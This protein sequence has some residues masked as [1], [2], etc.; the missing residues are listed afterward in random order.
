[1][2][3]RKPLA[4]TSAIALALSAQAIAEEKPDN[5][6]LDQQEEIVIYGEKQ[7]KSLQETPVSVGV[8]T[9]EDLSNS[10]IMDFN[11]VYNRLANVSSLRGGNESLFSIRGISVQGLADN[12]AS[13]T[14]GVYVDD[15]AL[16]NLSIRYN[17][18]NVWDAEQ[19]EVYR[20]PQG[21]IQGSNSLAGAVYVKTADPSYEWSGKAQAT[22]GNFNTKRHSIAGGGAIIDDT[23]AIRIAADDYRSD[24][25]VENVTRNEKDYAGF[26][27]QNVRG[28]ILFEPT[29]KLSTLLTVAHAKN[30]MG[31]NPASVYEDPYS[32]KAYSDHNAFH[33]T[34]INSSSLKVS[35]DLTDSLK[36]TSL[37][38]YS[39]ELFD[40]KD[41]FDSTAVS[42]GTVESTGESESYSQEL[43]LNFESDSIQG[44]AGLYARKLNREDIWLA[45]DQIDKSEYEKTAIDTLTGVFGQDAQ[46]AGLIFMAVPDLI[47]ATQ[48]YNSKYESMNYAIFGE[49]TFA[50]TDKLTLTVGARYDV[51]DQDRNQVTF[52]DVD[53]VTTQPL[54]FPLDPVTEAQIIGGA[55]MLLQALETDAQQPNEDAKT[56]YSAFLPKFAAQYHFTE[57]LN[58]AFVVQRGYRA[59]GSSVNLTTS[60]IIAYDPEYTWNYEL[61]LRSSF[62]TLS[63]NANVF[64][65]DWEDQQVTVSPN[66]DPRNSYVGNAGKSSLY[67]AEIE[68]NNQLTEELMIFAN[69]G[70]VHTEFKKYSVVDYRDVVNN[71]GETESEAYFKSYA[72]NQFKSAPEFTA[73]LGFNYAMENGFRLGMDANYQGESYVDNENTLK[74]EARTLLNAKVGYQHENVGAYLWSTNLTDE[75]Y[76]SSQFD[77]GTVEGRDYITTG[78]PRMFGITMNVAF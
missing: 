26:T 11:D 78:A 59:G 53:T 12:T 75:E 61:A 55:Q 1:M 39:H 6:L 37:S 2:S 38:T 27:R 77:P 71:N 7:D 14:A 31:D 35:Y 36:L 54:G 60:E 22:Y 8:I 18:M 5:E 32:L 45:K 51:E 48:D 9:S 49:T 16:D 20:G 33:N 29:D 64:Y 72:G 70:Y 67:G 17:G 66:G 23:L 42:L 74:N 13:F 34:Q 21:T 62:D 15:V 30:N 24:N 73:A 58:T 46:T 50:A 57:N 40:R 47:A 56:D 52:A 44:V 19:V 25:Y 76:I 41:D 65:T 10:T 63:I 68:I 3:T 4:L 43:R 69:A 28:K